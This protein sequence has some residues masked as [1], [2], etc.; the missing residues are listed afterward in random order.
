[1]FKLRYTA[2][3]VRD[4]EKAI[5]FCTN[6]LGMRLTSRV[7]V[8]ETKGEFA[9]VRPADSD[10]H[11]EINWYE[12]QDYRSGDELDHIAF[13]IADLTA[14][15]SELAKKGITPISN[16]RESKNSRCTYITDPSGIWKELYEKT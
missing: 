3:Q 12:G 7:K 6:V 4:L 16:T 10:H 2:I 13:E 1:L 11:I 8:P 14:A 15:P 5:N 9:T